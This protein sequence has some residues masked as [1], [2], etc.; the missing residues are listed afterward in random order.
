MNDTIANLTVTIKGTQITVPYG[1]LLSDLAKDYQQA[2]QTPILLA[3]VNNKLSELNHKVK[4]N[5]MIDFLDLTDK[6]GYRTYQRSLSFLLAKATQDVLT[7]LD[8]GEPKIVIQFSI[9][10]GFYC[11]LKPKQCL[12][13]ATVGAIKNRMLE[14]IQAN[15][16][17]EKTTVKLHEALKIFKQQGM[18]DKLRLF[19]YR[20]ASNVNL[21]C[22]DGFYDY[23]YGYMATHTGMLSNFDL[24]PYD[25]GLVLQFVNRKY[26]QQVAEFKPDKS[27]FENLKKTSRWGVLMNVDNVGDLNHVIAEGKLNELT[28]VTEALMEKEIAQVADRIMADIANKHFVFIAGP[29]SS[30]KTTFSHRL[31]I[32]L[33]AHG[34]NPKPIAVDNYFVNREETPRDEFGQYDFECLEAIDIRGFNDDMM[35][36]LQGKE[37]QLP[38]FNFVTGQREYKG[39]FLTLGPKDVLVI[40]GIHGLNPKLA[41]SIP[42]ENKFKIYISALTQLNIDDHNRIPTT[43]ARLLRR[44][45]RDNQYRGATAQRSI[46]MWPSV[47]R[48]EELYIFPFQEEAD[49]LFNSALLYELSI[50]KQYAEPLLFNVPRES[51]EYIEAKRL[52]KFLSYFLGASSDMI[53][54]NSLLREFIGGSCFRT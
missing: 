11:E 52:I 10:A 5:A 50:L 2:Y 15:H 14:L 13:H 17:F 23:F 4:E 47:R 43:D 21:Y 19:H 18:T 39:N 3:V 45:V 28:L 35:Q 24:I 42:E 31:S 29:S 46:S 7:T 27:L 51:E 40:E 48:G 26:P 20:N 37:V 41:S 1:I 34:L 12:D 22:I 33:K 25:E 16:A 36:L 38:T 49:V 9:N 54:Q 30:G 44:I 6:D 32:Q 8:C 53:P